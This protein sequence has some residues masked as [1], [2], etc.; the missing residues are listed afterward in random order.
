M[1]NV[2]EKTYENGVKAYLLA[3]ENGEPTTTLHR[4]DGPAFIDPNSGIE[5]YFINGEQQAIVNTK[6]N[7]AFKLKDGKVVEAEIPEATCKIKETGGSLELHAEGEPAV[8][9]KQQVE[10]FPAGTKFYIEDSR[11]TRA[12]GPAI[13]FP[14]G[15]GEYFI[16]DVRVTKDAFDNYTLKQSIDPDLLADL[17][18]AA[19]LK[20]EAAQEENAETEAEIESII[21]NINSLHNQN[22]RLANTLQQ[23]PFNL[24][25]LTQMNKNLLETE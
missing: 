14:D 2:I 6:A 8:I 1:P 9:L 5:M 11:Q 23:Q 18:T 7:V 22:K 19:E 15:R 3:D 17:S 10:Q 16:D 4:E 20:L 12:D 25:S 21:A 24:P 13:V